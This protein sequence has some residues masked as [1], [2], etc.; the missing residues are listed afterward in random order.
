MTDDRP[1]PRVRRVV[2]AHHHLWDLAVVRYPWL[3][4]PKEDPTDPHGV[5]MLQR[6]Y[7]VAD[8]LS[9]AEGVPLVASVHVEAAADPVDAVRETAWLQ[10]VA[11]RHG[12]PHAIVPSVVL[13]ADDVDDV[14]A[15]HLAHPNVR[16]VRQMLDRDP[17]TGAQAE[18]HLMQDPAWL[19]GLARLAPLGLSFDLQVLPS[20]LPVAARVAADNGELTF[21]LNHGGYHVPASPEAR[22]QWRAGVRSLGELP[23]VVVKASGYDTVDPSWPQDGVDDFLAVL[24]DAFGVD[25]VLFGSNFPVDGRTIAYPRLVETTARALHSLDDDQRDRVFCRNAIRT[26]RLA[27]AGEPDE[28]NDV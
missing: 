23:N 25:R 17:A 24:L 5:G 20:Q 13:Q 1:S 16:G 27:P 10:S 14:L 9:D 26:Y 11:D 28:G 21:V 4:G 12:F 2:D 6:N 7:T 18:T 15:G 3:Q 8:L 22:A 19:R